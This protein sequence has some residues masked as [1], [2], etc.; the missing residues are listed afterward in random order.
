MAA[1]TVR[2]GYRVE[3][4]VHIPPW[5]GHPGALDRCWRVQEQIER[6]VDGFADT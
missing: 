1:R 4:F 5:E 3:V 6:H 2:S